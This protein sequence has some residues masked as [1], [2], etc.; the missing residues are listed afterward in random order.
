MNTLKTLILS[1]VLVFVASIASAQT[2]LSN[3]TLNGAVTASQD[4]VVLG[5]ASAS[6]GSNVGAPAAG[7]FLWVEHEQM[8]ILSM[9]GTRANVQ[10]ATAGLQ[11]AHATSAVVFTGP[12]AAFHEGP[13]PMK[14]CT[15][16]TMGT[17]PWI[18]INPASPA[19][20]DIGL[21]KS[22]IWTFTNLKPITYNSVDPY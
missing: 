3:T 7:Q 11:G 20:G 14:A 13:P 5:S 16:A 8:R 21:C 9:V 1:I 15:T 10:R 22:S 4:F 19:F 2:V 17:R 18:V 12:G 6:S